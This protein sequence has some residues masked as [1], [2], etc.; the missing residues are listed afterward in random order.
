[1]LGLFIPAFSNILIRPAYKGGNALDVTKEAWNSQTYAVFLEELF[2][3]GDEKYKAFHRRIVPGITG[4]HGVSNQKLKAVMKDLAKNSDLAGFYDFVKQG[5]SYEER[6][7][8]GMVIG[9]LFR[10]DFLRAVA[11][12]E[13]YLPHI[14]NWA[15]CDGLVAD[16]RPIIGKH[17]DEM[18]PYIE[19]Y[20]ASGVP[21]TVRVG[22]VLLNGNY[23]DKPYLN[24]IFALCLENPCKDEYYVQMG[25][26]WLLSTCYIKFPE[27][28]Y[29]FLSSGTIKD[30]FVLR[31]TVSKICDSFRVTDE[32]KKK[33][34]GML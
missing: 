21:Y 11:E 17:L 34:K 24:Q 20:I 10:K 9:R 26:A 15:L 28:T 29:Q 27:E 7:L 14:D 1:M 30:A 13:D 22:Y 8:R 4:F 5:V 33:A 32:H 31:K 16:T 6:M 23:V 3:M 18:L 19:R 25:I 2:S 12:I